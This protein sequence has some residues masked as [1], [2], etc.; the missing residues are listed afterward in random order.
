[1]Q[2]IILT[3]VGFDLMTMYGRALALTHMLTP[4]VAL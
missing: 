2:A 1:L 4:Y 3:R